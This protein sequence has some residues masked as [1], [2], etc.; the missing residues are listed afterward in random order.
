VRQSLRSRSR[1]ELVENN[2]YLKGM[3]L[4][5]VNDLVG[6]GPK[7]QVTDPRLTDERA[8]MIEQ[9]FHAWSRDSAATDPVAD[10]HGQDCGR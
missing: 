8:Q 1:Y 3:V 5:K 4:T 9:R 7:L 2:S 10:D 6:S